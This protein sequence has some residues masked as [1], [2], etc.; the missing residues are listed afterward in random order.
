M[1]Y[2][3]MFNYTE[4]GSVVIEAATEEE[5]MDILDTHLDDKGLN[6][7]VVDTFDREWRVQGTE[8]ANYLS[9]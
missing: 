1:I 6:D 5:A 2:K 3:V 8:E 4:S 7:L 9:M